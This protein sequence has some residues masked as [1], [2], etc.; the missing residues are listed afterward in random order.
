M[1]GITTHFSVCMSDTPFK[2]DQ[3]KEEGSLSFRDVL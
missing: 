2:G 3:G 1:N